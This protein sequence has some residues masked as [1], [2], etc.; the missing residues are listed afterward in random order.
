MKNRDKNTPEKLFKDF[1]A[2]KIDRRSFIIAVLAFAGGYGLSVIFP[3]LQKLISASNSLT[4]EQEKILLAV[5]KHLF[6]KT[7]S[8]PGADEINALV[9]LQLVLLDPALDPRDQKFIKNGIG[10]LE[11]ECQKIFSMSFTGL[12]NGQKEHVLREIEKENWG[13]TW[14]SNLLKYIFETLLTDPIYGGNPDG[15]G[16]EWL[17]HIPGEP[18]PTNYNRYEIQS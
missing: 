7:E 16:W 9:Y 10:W 12:E 3:G 13:E 4:A 18:R 8:S 11:E 6:P 1:L 5:M 14:L 2:G 15:I 17:Q